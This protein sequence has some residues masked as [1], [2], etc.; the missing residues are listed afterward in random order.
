MRGLLIALMKEAVSISE[1][2]VSF[3]Q[4]TQ[5]NIPDD[6]FTKHAFRISVYLAENQAIQF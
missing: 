4:T 5:V 1:T 2:S 6:I 3:H